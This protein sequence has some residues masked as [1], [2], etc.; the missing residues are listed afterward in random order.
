MQ[1]SEQEGAGMTSQGWEAKTSRR[2]REK[3]IHVFPRYKLRLQV[4]LSKGQSCQNQNYFSALGQS[5]CKYVLWEK[6]FRWVRGF[7]FFF[8]QKICKI[9]QKR[10]RDHLVH[11]LPEGRISFV[12]VIPHAHLTEMPSASSFVL[13]HFYWQDVFSDVSSK[14]S[15]L[16]RKPI[17]ASHT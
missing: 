9:E 16:S 10:P 1:Q 12:S 14:A 8:S 11:P 6:V 7:F 17:S 13:N 2:G 5:L 3:K 4:K 15:L